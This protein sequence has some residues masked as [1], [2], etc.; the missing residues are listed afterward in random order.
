MLHSFCQWYFIHTRHLIKKENRLLSC[1]NHFHF[2]SYD[3]KRIKNKEKKQKPEN[4]AIETD[5]QI[6]WMISIVR[7]SAFVW[8]FAKGVFVLIQIRVNQIRCSANEANCLWILM[9]SNVQIYELIDSDRWWRPQTMH[10]FWPI[11]FR[12]I[13]I[14]SYKKLSTI[15]RIINHF[16]IIIKAILTQFTKIHQNETGFSSSCCCVHRSS[17]EIIY[18]WFFFLYKLE[19]FLAE[20]NLHI[21]LLLLL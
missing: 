16:L 2:N 1:K 18:F 6:H 8:S 12:N 14:E 13:R 15:I 20:I 9:S 11:P 10:S 4:K 21:R 3:R 19:N 7:L 5:G 17:C